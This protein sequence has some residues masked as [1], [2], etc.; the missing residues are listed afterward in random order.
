MPPLYG[1]WHAQAS[2][3]DPGRRRSRRMPRWV[4]ELNLD[5]RHRVAAGLGTGVVQKKPGSLMEAAWQQVGKVLEGNARIRFGQMAML[6][7]DVWHRREL[8]PLAAAGSEQLLASR[9]GPHARV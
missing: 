2:R 8:G 5:P 6:T 7:L 3:L 9:P 1:R 4:D